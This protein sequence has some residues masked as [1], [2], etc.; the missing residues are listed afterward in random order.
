MFFAILFA[1]SGSSKIK[2]KEH[3]FFGQRFGVVA[4]QKRIVFPLQT[5][6]QQ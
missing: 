5:D 4:W 2:D 1:F 6:K 3:D